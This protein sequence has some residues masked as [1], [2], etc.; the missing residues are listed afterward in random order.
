MTNLVRQPAVS[1]VIQ[2]GTR[3]TSIGVR[4]EA[5]RALTLLLSDNG[6]KLRLRRGAPSHP[7]TQ[8]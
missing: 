8:G 7:Q 6:V 3:N 1:P 5:R 4:F 2:A